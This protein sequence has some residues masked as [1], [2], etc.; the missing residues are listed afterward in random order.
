MSHGIF[1]L[2]KEVLNLVEQTIRNLN[3]CTKRVQISLS[4]RHKP[5]LPGE[6]CLMLSRLLVF[7]KSLFYYYYYLVS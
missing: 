1:S 4:V 2:K 6:H 3:K 7:W 5:K